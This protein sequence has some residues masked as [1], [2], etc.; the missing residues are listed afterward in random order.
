MLT[1]LA[2][3]AAS[4]AYS[5]FIVP[6]VT[7]DRGWWLNTEAFAPV[8]AGQPT[9]WLVQA[10]ALRVTHHGAVPFHPGYGVG[11][12]AQPYAY[13]WFGHASPPHWH[14]SF[15][16]TNYYRKWEKR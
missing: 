11:V 15:G 2:L 6:A 7:G 3:I 13:G 9:Y 10:P 12:A 14:H 8:Y 5:F 16:V 1:T 4:A